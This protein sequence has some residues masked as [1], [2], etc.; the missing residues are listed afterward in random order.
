MFSYIVEQC[1]LPSRLHKTKYTHVTRVSEC[2]ARE[3]AS[4]HA[5]IT[6]RLFVLALYRCMREKSFNQRASLRPNG[7][8]HSLL[9][10]IMWWIISISLP[11]PLNQPT[12]HSFTR[13]SLS[14]SDFFSIFIFH[15]LKMFFIEIHFV[16]TFSYPMLPLHS[17]PLRCSSSRSHCLL[18]A[19][20][21]MA[22]SDARVF[23]FFPAAAMN[24]NVTKMM[25][26]FSTACTLH[27]PC[28]WS[29]CSLYFQFDPNLL[30]QLFLPI[31]AMQCPPR[32]GIGKRGGA[33]KIYQ[34]IHTQMNKYFYANRRLWMQT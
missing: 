17:T 5:S 6:F 7:S 24:K 21:S 26:I 9:W 1:F 16:I 30:T 15:H 31:F 19:W 2:K 27:C 32:H 8:L 13:R 29:S 33:T 12:I 23:P 20:L 11:I 3:E 22:F 18:L 10:F 34:F 14:A 4:I 28:L 25:F